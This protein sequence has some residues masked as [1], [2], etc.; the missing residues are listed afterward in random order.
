MLNKAYC[1]VLYYT[2][3][4]VSMVTVLNI[5]YDLR[6]SPVCSK[7]NFL[8]IIF[9]EFEFESY[10]IIFYSISSTFREKAFILSLKTSRL[11]LLIQSK[12]RISVRSSLITECGDIAVLI[13]FLFAV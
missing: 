3:S 2:S 4:K 8:F 5:R 11:E 1:I 6:T 7:V 12:C 9:L 13:P 10:G